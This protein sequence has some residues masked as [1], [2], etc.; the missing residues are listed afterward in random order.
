MAKTINNLEIFAAGTHNAMSGKVTVTEADLDKIVDAFNSLEGTNIVKPHL[1]LGHTDAQK[2]FG[3]KDGIPSLGWIV[4]VWREGKKLLANVANVPDALI[5]MIK[6]GRYHNVS[7][8]IFWNAGIEHEG[9]TFSRVLSAVS[10]LGVE[11]PAVKTLEG[12]AGA[13]FQAKQ[14]HQFSDV[15]AIEL[16]STEEGGSE[17]PDKVDKTVVA[18][19]SQDQTDAL[20][21]SAVDKALKEQEAKFADDKKSAGK[22]LEV[23]EARAKTAEKEVG[24]V[25]AAAAVAEATTLVDQSIK[26]GKLLPKQ[27]DFALAALS[28]KDTKLAFGEKGETKSMPELFKEFLECSGKVIDTSEQGDGKTKTVEFS[29]AAEEVDHKVKALRSEDATGKLDYGQAFDKVLAG[30]ADLNK[31]YLETMV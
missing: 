12:L 8:E 27:R 5:D 4:R 20:I 30:D 10:I 7:A 23:M 18:I 25:K 29:N 15:S 19:Y 1:K 21:A 26:D 9:Q 31:R 24:E 6:G 14:I 22:E 2:W 16:T 28:A 11:M 13:L 17:M 3:Q